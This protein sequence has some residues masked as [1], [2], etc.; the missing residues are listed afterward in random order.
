MAFD[1]QN[2]AN[3]LSAAGKSIEEKAAGVSAGLVKNVKESA[4]IDVNGLASAIEGA[5]S[6]FKGASVDLGNSLNGFT[7]LS[8]NDT[9]SSGLNGIAN[10]IA[11]GLISSFNPLFGG[12]MIGQLLNG[13]VQDNP[14]A[15]FASSNYEITLGC[16]TPFELNFP[17]FTYRNRDPFF[18][19]IRSSGGTTRGSAISAE[20]GG[21]TEYFIDD[22]EI[23]S[24]IA[25]NA[26]TRLTNA[27]SFNFTVTEPYSMGNF[28]QALQVAA[29]SSGHKNYIDAPYVLIVQFKGWDDFGRPITVPNTRRVF[30]LKFVDIRFE[31][32]EGGSTY[33]V[34]AIPFNEIALTDE[35][36]STHTDTQMRGRTVA[37]ML[38]TGG[39]S[40]SVILNNRELK[41]VQAGQQKIANQYVIMFPNELTSSSEG[42]LSAGSNNAGATTASSFSPESDG[43]RELSEEQKQRLFESITGITDGEIPED[44]DAELQKIAGVVVR[45]SQYGEQIRDYAEK[46]ENLNVIGSS[47]IVKSNLDAGTQPMATPKLSEDEDQPGKVNRC[48]V[49]RS[50]DTRCMTFSPG[51]RIQDIIYCADL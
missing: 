18:T 2:W 44:F 46:E 22:I 28:L 16:L 9:I 42:L 12:G 45:R 5:A 37:E 20:V 35:N 48:Q 51:K 39:E 31:V 41:K 27:T 13:G 4:N 11:S 15:Q 24:I 34:Q 6:E 3:R 19:I 40:L 33:S 36:Q 43:M 29:L 21:K 30:P 32:S 25:P 7:G 26:G 38:Q 50:Q 23:D 10:N 17:D 1:P 47:P 49:G 14:L 8:I